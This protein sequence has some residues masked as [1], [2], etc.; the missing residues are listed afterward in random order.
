MAHALARDLG[1]LRIEFIPFDFDTLDQ[2]VKDDQFDI[3]MSGIFIVR[4]YLRK[5]AFSNNYMRTN[6]A[7][8]VKDHLRHQFEFRVG[9]GIGGQLDQERAHANRGHGLAQHAHAVGR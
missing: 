3:A 8:V 9:L 1:G 5:V 6:W 2:Q 7:F 4:S